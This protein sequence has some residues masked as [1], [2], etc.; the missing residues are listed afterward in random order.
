MRGKSRAAV[1]NLLRVNQAE[2]RV[3]RK[4]HG[5]VEVFLSSQMRIDRLA[6]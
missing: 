5:V 4:A 1:A 6:Q 2:S 3:L